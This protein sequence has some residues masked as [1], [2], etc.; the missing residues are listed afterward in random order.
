[1]VQQENVEDV[2]EQHR[3]RRYNFLQVG[4]LGNL[5]TL[6]QTGALDAGRPSST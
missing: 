4:C 5:L 2:P 6:L 3:V 1:M